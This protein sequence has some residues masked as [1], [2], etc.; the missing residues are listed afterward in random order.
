VKAA[1]HPAALGTLLHLLGLD[2]RHKVPWRNHYVTGATVGPAIEALLEAGLV[3]EA[4]RPGFLPETDRVFVATQAGKE[5]A[6]AEH[7]RRFPKL[8]RGEAR[9]RHWLDYSDA[10]GVSFAE[11]LRRGLYRGEA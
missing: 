2:E 9:Y 7:R 3:E 10:T 1:L 5:A 6:R 4:R 11:Y 8:T